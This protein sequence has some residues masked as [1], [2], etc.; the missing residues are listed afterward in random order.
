[1]ADFTF[2]SL[3]PV[4]FLDRSSAVF[5]DRVA[6]VDG[7]LRYTYREFAQRCD[8]LVS[9]LAAQGI[10]EGDRVAAVCA[11][12]HVMLELHQAVPARGALLVSINIRL[13][14]DEMAFI[15]EHSGARALIATEEFGQRARALAESAGVAV[16]VDD[17]SGEYESWLAAST[18]DSSDRIAVA[19]TSP[20][21]INYTSG[22]TGSPKGVMYHHRG[23]YLQAVAMAYHARLGPEARYLWTLPMF[24][25]E[26]WCFTWAVTAAG[27][28]H[29]CL[30]AID[31]PRI[32]TLLQQ[33]GITHL[34]GAPTVLAMIAEDEA[35]GP[36]ENRVHVDTGG[37]PPSPALLSRLEP[38]GMDVTHLYG[39]TETY[40]PLAINE[41]QPEWNDLD[42]NDQSRLRARQGVGNIIAA[43]LRVLE[44]DGRDVP[45]DGTTMGEIAARGNDV[46]LGYYRDQA[47]TDAATRSG[48]F[49]TG[50][51]G[52]MH[53][54]G[55]VEIRDRSKDIIISGGETIASIEIEQALDSHPAV[56]ESAVI[57]APDEKWG[58][59]PAAYVTTR[60]DVEPSELIDHVRGQLAGFKTPRHIIFGELPKTSTGKIQKNIL[61]QQ[62]Q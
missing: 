38:L 31:P 62:Q 42:L 29:V 1:M 34:S 27:G 30:R 9:A 16:I 50:D 25:C 40:G 52:V 55:Y 61:R 20:L 48:C 13:S 58:E 5:A 12:S 21:A 44:V 51:L 22:T 23:A 60:T 36:L 7:D 18:P 3:S 8:R 10:G 59:V 2:E 33:E 54:D 26:G 41:W 24:H 11:N 35:A 6:I 28:T 45:A 46:M 17:D 53:P 57:A 14:F 15:L 56:I 32:W 49:L 39:L 43:P 37:A 4:S 47:A 19:E